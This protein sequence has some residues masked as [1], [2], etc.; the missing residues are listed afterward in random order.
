MIPV[1]A[2]PRLRADC[3]SSP[4][5]HSDG[6]LMDAKV[7]GI[8]PS[9]ARAQERIHARE[10]AAQARAGQGIAPVP[11]PKKDGPAQTD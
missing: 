3:P 8:A 2:L 4:Q 10:M 11:P 1:E 7:Q 6:P 5:I 9:L